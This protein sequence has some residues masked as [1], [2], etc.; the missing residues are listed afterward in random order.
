M[1]LIGL[2][3]ETYYDNNCS[4]SKLS[5]EEYINH[6]DFKVHCVGIKI[7]DQDPYVIWGRDDLRRTAFGT[8]DDPIKT[9]LTELFSSGDH[10][11]YGHNMAFDG[12]ILQWLYGIKP[13]L[14]ACTQRMVAL[15]AP[16]Q[17][18]SLANAARFFRIGMKGKELITIKGTRTVPEQHRP[19]IERYCKNDI[20]LSFKLMI[21]LKD[22]IPNE[23]FNLMDITL[24]MFLDRPFDVDRKALNDF[25]IKEAGHKAAKLGAAQKLYPKLT[26]DILASN[27]QFAEWIVDQGIDFKQVPSPTARN[28]DNMK[29]PLD[30]NSDEFRALRVDYPDLAPVWEAR[31][32]ISSNINATRAQRM[33]IHSDLSKTNLQGRIGFLLQTYGA[34]NTL[35]W[36]GAN[37]VNGQNLTKGTPLRTSLQAPPDHM[38]CVHDQSNIEARMLAWLAGEK[39]ILEAFAQKRDLY[40]E[41]AT[42]VYGYEVSK[43]TPIE[44]FVGKTCVLGL[45]YQMG[46]NRLRTTLAIGM[47]GM[48]VVVSHEQARSFVA[49]YRNTY[50]AIVRLWHEAAGILQLMT[51]LEP[52]KVEEWR[53]LKIRRDSIELPNATFLQYPG[54]HNRVDPSTG[55]SEVVYKG[56][57]GFV[58]MFP[59]KLVENI[60]Q[61]LS[62]I[63]VA[64][65]TLSAEKLIGNRGQIGLLVHDEIV[66]IVSTED[67]FHKTYMEKQAEIMRTPP[68]WC[69]NGGLV[70]DVEGGYALNYSK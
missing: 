62:R 61:A 41:F 12:T 52:G 28:P 30:Q 54:I 21:K 19:G 39:Q 49:L 9:H 69:N 38:I 51:S 31:L 23:E 57:N 15:M 63:V 27:N 46:A 60:I 33:L 10:T 20:E 59:G 7:D 68:D 42:M 34:S 3:F 2:D 26:R 40:S 37:K 24:R 45:G 50:K 58:R 11:A 6:P 1:S 16:H 66:A 70:L 64:D 36:S 65:N 8:E 56:R 53:G 67:D 22:F 35:R 14:W 25:I 47:G 17:S 55:E 4:L 32:A 13:T 43:A 18:H 5:Y 44:R 29:W 48:S